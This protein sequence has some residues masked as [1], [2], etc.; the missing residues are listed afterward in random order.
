M[1]VPRRNTHALRAPKLYDGP[2]PC[3]P[4]AEGVVKG[5]ASVDAEWRHW[6]DPA[7]PFESGAQP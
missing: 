6:P 7:R 3:S 1:T 2:G 5:P 4:P